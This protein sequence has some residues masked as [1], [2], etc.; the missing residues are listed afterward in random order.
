LPKSN[1]SESPRWSKATRTLFV[2]DAYFRLSRQRQRIENLE[3]LL[4]ARP[5]DDLNS[6]DYTSPST[7]RGDA[8]ARDSLEA[9]QHDA[10]DCPNGMYEP[11]SES[12]L[13]ATQKVDPP[14]LRGIQMNLPFSVL[15][16]MDKRNPPEIER[17]QQDPVKAGLIDMVEAQMMFDMQA[18]ASASSL[19]VNFSDCAQLPSDSGINAIRCVLCSIAVLSDRLSTFHQIV[20]SSLRWFAL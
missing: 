13:A 12:Q 18:F 17:S 6:Q 5:Q 1:L 8:A 3:A 7:P 11:A 14:S 20:L 9:L 16:S 4:G 15:S 10:G 19:V 2:D